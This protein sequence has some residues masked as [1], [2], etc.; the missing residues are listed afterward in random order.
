MRADV[1]SARPQP[2]AH[3]FA[4]RLAPVPGLAGRV[5]A[6]RRLA[7]PA[8]AAPVL[9][10][11]A[12]TIAAGLAGCGTQSKAGNVIAVSAGAC[13]TGWQQVSA[14]MQ[15][16]QIRNSAT[17]GAEV[18]LINPA[19]GA[20]YAEVAGLGRGRPGRCAWTWAPAVTR[21]AA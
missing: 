18:D 8:L 9:A 14:G 1:R 4:G 15:T 10:V 5:R 12:A 16:F 6:A 3:R 7:A 21:S 20:I 19:S 2:L 11:L 13:G 17:G